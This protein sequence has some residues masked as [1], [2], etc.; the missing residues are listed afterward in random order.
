M[1]V[2]DVVQLANGEIE[3]DLTLDSDNKGF[4]L[5]VDY[6]LQNK[7]CANQTGYA[8]KTATV[9][10]VAAVEATIQPQP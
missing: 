10:V 8:I 9:A 3:L 1:Q 7:F 2:D 5:S 4:K 6:N